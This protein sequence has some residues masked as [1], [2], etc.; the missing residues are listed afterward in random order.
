MEMTA[1]RTSRSNFRRIIDTLALPLRAILGPRTNSNWL[2]TSLRDERMMEVKSH[3]AGRCLDIGCGPYNVFI[4]FFHPVGEGVDFYPYEGVPRIIEDAAR[5]P[6]PSNTFDT[7]TL[8][9]VG[10]HIP[11]ALRKIEFREFYRI[12]KPGGRLVMTEGEPITQWLIHQFAFLQG[13]LTGKKSLDYERGMADDEQFCLSHQEIL[14]LYE[15]AGFQAPDRY[16]FQLGLNKIY[17]GTKPGD[18]KG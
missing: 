14:E 5:F 2:F 3:V 1:V 9:A 12:L 10:G 8:I 18:S 6:Y 11:R 4:R 7:L 13:L 17:V 16:F 15:Q